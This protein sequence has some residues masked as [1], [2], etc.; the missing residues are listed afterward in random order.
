V[1]TLAGGLWRPEAITA[2]NLYELQGIIF[3]RPLP[4]VHPVISQQ[5]SSLIVKIPGIQS[6]EKKHIFLAESVIFCI[7]A[8]IH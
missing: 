7:S 3:F 6:Q 1:N 4:N 2:V 8:G 5:K